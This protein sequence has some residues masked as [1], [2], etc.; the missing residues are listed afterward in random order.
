[1]ALTTY[2]EAMKSAQDF[3]VFEPNGTQHKGF[4]SDIRVDRKTLPEGWNAYD[5][6]E[7]DEC[8]DDNW[9]GTIEENYVVVNHAGTFLTQD[10]LNL[11]NSFGRNWANL[12]EDAKNGEWDYSFD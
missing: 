4:W 7:N 12:G 2:D 5:I 3:S 8:D 1:M 11:P 6:R 9:L 10:K